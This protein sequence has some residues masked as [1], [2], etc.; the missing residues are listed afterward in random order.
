MALLTTAE[1]TMCSGLIRWPILR[2]LLYLAQALY[3]PE[4]DLRHNKKRS[5]FLSSGDSIEQ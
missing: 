3:A 5:P 4:G 1:V 2:I